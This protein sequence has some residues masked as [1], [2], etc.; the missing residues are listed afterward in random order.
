MVFSELTP[1]TWSCLIDRPNQVTSQQLVNLARRLNGGRNNH[2]AQRNGGGV[3]EIWL[4]G[5]QAQVRAVG[6][7]AEDRTQVLP[8]VSRVRF[9]KLTSVLAIAATSAVAEETSFGV[10]V[11]GG[12]SPSKATATIACAVI[13]GS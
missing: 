2:V 8:N 12:C 13:D 9:R 10:T 7:R 5:G 1:R 11:S 4:R 3:L 6:P